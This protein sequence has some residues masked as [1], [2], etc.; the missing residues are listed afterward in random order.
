MSSTEST[1]AAPWELV[2]F[3]I[4]IEEPTNKNA[5]SSMSDCDESAAGEERDM[6]A[7]RAQARAA[8]G[9]ALPASPSVAAAALSQQPT[10]TPIMSR[11]PS[12]LSTYYN[13]VCSTI[14]LSTMADSIHVSPWELA[15][16]NNGGVLCKKDLTRNKRWDAVFE[17]LL[18]YVD[19]RCKEETKYMPEYQKKTWVWDGNVPFLYQTKD[20]EKGCLGN[21]V[22]TQRRAKRKGTLKED[23]EVLLMTIGLNWEASKRHDRGRTWICYKQRALEKLQKDRDAKLMSLR[24]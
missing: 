15:F 17:C 13:K 9:Y 14:N 2:S 19:E 16:M 18:D 20:D 24:R 8:A 1:A 5:E 10:S 22:D 11:E 7:I 23:R 4:L 12:S 21:W 6:D 3:D